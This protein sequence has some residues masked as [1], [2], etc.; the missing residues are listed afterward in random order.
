VVAHPT[1]QPAGRSGD[2]AEQPPS[3]L[4]GPA[5]TDLAEL[6]PARRR[7]AA[8]TRQAL[9]DAA[10]R[11][12][13]R[14]GY[15]A[16]TVRD[17]ATDAGV[18]VALISR[19]FESKEGL[20]Q[21]C[22]DTAGQAVSRSADDVGAL[23][24]VARAISR[25]VAGL[26][27]DGGPPDTLLLLLRSSGDERAEQSRMAALRSYSERLAQLAGWRA[28]EPDPDGLLLRAQVLLAAT[29]GIN[30]MRSVGGLAALTAADEADLMAPLSDLVGALL[31]VSDA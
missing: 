8:R 11:R 19:Y 25:Q 2:A 13:A 21:A 14:N 9:L 22:L 16:T 31:P 27:S 17:I 28:G 3:D 29:M 26:A 12:F 23:T 4:P 7:D 6:T 20:F 10:R 15:G 24:E 30:L 1:E 5:P 18:N